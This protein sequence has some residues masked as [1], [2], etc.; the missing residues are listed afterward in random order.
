MNSYERGFSDSKKELEP[1]PPVN[2]PA[3]SIYMDGYT[4]HRRGASFDRRYKT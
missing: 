2:E 3:R 4:D 1:S